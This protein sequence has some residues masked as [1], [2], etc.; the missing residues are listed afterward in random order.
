LHPDKCKH[1][2]AQ[3]AFACLNQA[4]KNLQDEPAKKR[5][6][7]IATHARKQMTEDWTKQKKPAS[8]PLFEYELKLKT[9][10]I[11]V[12]LDQEETK[13]EEMRMKNERRVKEYVIK[14][15]ENVKKDEVKE[16]EWESKRE[17]RVEGWRA[18][19]AT[20]KK[21]KASG[22]TLFKPPKVKLVTK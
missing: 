7:Q 3:D 2:K 17:T 4:Y 13:A 14:E 9:Q 8:G 11:I 21:R 20:G 22:A 18:F 12:D 5:F 15:R 1:F 19:Q 10:K 6:V 16:E